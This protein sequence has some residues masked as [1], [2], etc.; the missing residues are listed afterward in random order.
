[1]PTQ[2]LEHFRAD[3]WRLQNDIVQI[4]PFAAAA[5]DAFLGAGLLREEAVFPGL[6]ENLLGTGLRRQAGTVGSVIVRRRGSWTRR[7][8]DVLDEKIDEFCL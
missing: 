5:R 1:V 2:P 7:C 8:G 4:L 3:L 6:R